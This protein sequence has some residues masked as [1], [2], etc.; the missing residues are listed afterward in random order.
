MNCVSFAF[1]T[2]TFF[3]ATTSTRTNATFSA[4]S[5]PLSSQLTIW[6]CPTTESTTS[7]NVQVEVIEEGIRSKATAKRLRPTSV[8]PTE[9]QVKIQRLESS[10]VSKEEGDAFDLSFLGP[11]EESRPGNPNASDSINLSSILSGL[12][13]NLCKN[14]SNE[15]ESIVTNSM[16]PVGDPH[17][18]V[19]VSTSVAPPQSQLDVE[20]IKQAAVSTGITTTS[21][22]STVL[23]TPVKGTAK[24][25]SKNENSVD[26][27]K[28][29]PVAFDPQWFGGEVGYHICPFGS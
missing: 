4:P 23:T 28:I 13:K 12:T 17:K 22:K 5:T 16:E 21:T 6:G 8:L 7:S 2:I 11:D 20:T 24:T 15:P 10:N 1:S 26:C 9:E 14:T 3:T 18:T 29:Q 19:A 27:Y 25:P